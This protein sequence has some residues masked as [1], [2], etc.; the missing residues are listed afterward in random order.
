MRGFLLL[1][2]VVLSA[3]TMPVK[4]S[5]DIKLIH[6]DH[7][8]AGKIWDV[9][10]GR[11]IDKQALAKSIV[12][13]DYLLLGETHDN[14][15]HHQGQAWAISQL[16]AAQRSAVVAFEMISDQQGQVISG[17]Q[18]D[19]VASLIAGLDHIETNWGYQRFYRDIFAEALKADYAVLSA[20][21]DREDMMRFARK[22][23]AELPHEIKSI[24]DK[25]PLPSEQEAASRKEIEGSHCGMINEQMTVAMML[26]QRAKDAKMAQS[27]GANQRVDVRVLV[28]G[29]GHV[30]EDRGVPFYLL[31]SDDEKK[32]VTIAWAEVQPDVVDASV[33]AAHWGAEHLPFDYVWFTPR[34]DR[35]DPCVQFRQ[36]MKKKAS[37]AE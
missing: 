35:P 4:K 34:V 36:H 37:Q 5:A 29:S 32:Q 16:A 28:A 26:V 20:N 19:S 22:G 11:F 7:V 23:E 2:C 17:K 15:L 13:S 25:K 1:L 33:Y 21:F 30:R 18:Y 6:S 3:C 9:K 14:P 12:A 10:A 24:L 8:L 27:M 31:S